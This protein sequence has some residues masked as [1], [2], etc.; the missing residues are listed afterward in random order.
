MPFSSRSTISMTGGRCNHVHQVILSQYFA[1]RINLR[2]AEAVVQMPPP[3]FGELEFLR[4]LADRA[5]HLI[6][7]GGE[8]VQALAH[9]EPVPLALV[10]GERGAFDG[11]NGRCIHERAG[12]D[13]PTQ[14][15]TQ[16]VRHGMINRHVVFGHGAR[17][18]GSEVRHGMGECRSDD[19]PACVGVVFHVVQRS[20]REDDVRLHFA[21]HGGESSQEL[22]L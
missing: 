4:Q 7:P 21:N 1:Q 15:D 13:E 9:I 20:V 18:R 8:R 10:R 2:P 5:A 17:R 14:R 19:E 16:A 22:M 3:A 6:D 11:L 12:R